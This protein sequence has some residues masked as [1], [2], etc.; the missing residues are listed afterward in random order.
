MGKALVL[1]E[2]HFSPHHIS[3][4]GFGMKKKIIFLPVVASLFWALGS[5]GQTVFNY[6]GGIQYYV[7]PFC[8]DSVIIEV[9]GAQGG[10]NTMGITGGAGGMS[11]GA[12]DV[13]A[14]DTLFV[15]VGG[16]NGYN[17]GGVP[18]FSGCTAAIGGY[19][20][21]G[22]DVRYPDTMLI[23]RV[24]VGGGGGGAAGSRIYTCGQGTGGGGGGGYYGGGGGA[25]W[26]WNST[27]VPTGGTQSSGG[28][29]GISNWTSVANING[30]PGSWFY[31]GNGGE[32]TPSNQGPTKPGAPGGYGGGMTGD[33]GS[34][35]GTFTYT[36]QSGA[37]GSGYVGGV[38]GGLMYN[39][40]RSGDGLVT[41]TPV[42]EPPEAADSIAGPSEV[43]QG[44]T[45][46]WYVAS[47]VYGASYIWSLPPGWMLHSGAGSDSV[48]VIAGDTSGMLGV[49]ALTCDTSAGVFLNVSVNPLPDV[50]ITG[51]YSSICI[52]A[53]ETLVAGGAISYLWSTMEVNDTIVVQPAFSIT[54]SVMGTDSNGCSNSAYYLLQVDSCNGVEPNDFS[55]PVLVYPNPGDGAFN[56]KVNEPVAIL[57]LQMMDIGGRMVYESVWTNV[58]A[59]TV[60]PVVPLL[61]GPGAYLLYIAADDRLLKQ[62]QLMR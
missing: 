19:G 22:S 27:I 50:V 10:V 53:A 14:G 34:F 21:G 6:T 23:H 17:G 62:R 11:R 9:Y 60:L 7:V 25:G 12:L 44:D 40:V 49:M 58:E 3:V 5:Q 28:S 33:T 8:V 61:S 13:S 43:C 59:G 48:W 46:L 18:G 36:G 57:R 31:G 20:G 35:A 41:I 32:N 47:P 51:E 54:Y 15:F 45:A 4:I 30:H 24:I 2:E 42:F 55:V 52:G 37:G 26:P 1:K 56:L 39:G 29:G 38:T 16:Q